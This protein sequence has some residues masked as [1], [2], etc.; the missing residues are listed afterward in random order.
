VP[1]ENPG[2]ERALGMQVGGVEHDHLT[3]HLHAAE[4]SAV[5]GAGPPTGQ[6]G[7]LW[8]A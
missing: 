1:A 7:K 4:A 3:H 2:P 5:E 6:G 8:R